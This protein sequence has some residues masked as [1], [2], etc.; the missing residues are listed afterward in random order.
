MAYN[1]TRGRFLS[2][3]RKS[4]K[5]RNFSTKTEATERAKMNAVKEQ[6]EKILSNPAYKDVYLIYPNASAA[7]ETSV[8]GTHP[9]DYGYY[10][11]AKSIEGPVLEILAKYGIK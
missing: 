5:V 6:F 11:W 3:G 7:H 1:H 10:L 9:D 2:K 8:D 4:D